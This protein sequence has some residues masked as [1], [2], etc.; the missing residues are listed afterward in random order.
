MHATATNKNQEI[1]TG[2]TLHT[3][4]YSSLTGWSPPHI[5]GSAT[6][7]L[8]HDPALH[9]IAPVSNVLPATCA[10][11]LHL[12]TPAPDDAAP[13]PKDSGAGTKYRASKP[14]QALSLIHI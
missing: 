2:V 9:A 12:T 6:Q 1:P 11:R 14:V 8:L 3:C 10:R 5:D 7:P 13:C 4:L